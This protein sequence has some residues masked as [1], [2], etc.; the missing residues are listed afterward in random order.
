[1]NFTTKIGEKNVISRQESF[2]PTENICEGAGKAEGAR[3]RLTAFGVDRY[4]TRGFQMN[5]HAVNI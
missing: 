3:N 5:S 1:M 4:G 2:H